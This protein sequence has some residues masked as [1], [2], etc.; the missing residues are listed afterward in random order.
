MCGARSSC[1]RKQPIFVIR[2]RPIPSSQCQCPTVAQA[3]YWRAGAYPCHRG[4][5]RVVCVRPTWQAVKRRE[6]K[7]MSHQLVKLEQCE[8]DMV[9]GGDFCTGFLVDLSRERA[10]KHGFLFP[11]W[12][13]NGFPRF[14]ASSISLW[15]PLASVAAADTAARIQIGL[16]HHKEG[17]VASQERDYGV[18]REGLWHRN[19]KFVRHSWMRCSFSAA[20]LET[21][22]E[23]VQ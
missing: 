22:R 7:E 20:P 2:N 3:A 17:A 6:V 12:V 16:W 18:T 5:S 21:A 9:R 23:T 4:L 14:V 13:P 8:T 11:P 1:N 19:G 15:F 10:N